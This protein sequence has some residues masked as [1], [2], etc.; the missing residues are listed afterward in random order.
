MVT[1]VPIPLAPYPDSPYTNGFQYINYDDSKDE[2]KTARTTIHN[3][4]MNWPAMM[5]KA[6][7]SM[8]NTDDTTFSRWF[9]EDVDVPG[10]D[11]PIDARGYVS[12]VFRQL[13]Q[14]STTSPTAKEVIKN[15]VNDKNDYSKSPTAPRPKPTSRPPPTP[16]TSAVSAWR[17]PP[18]P[19]TSTA[20]S[21]ATGQAGTCAR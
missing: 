5:Q 9:P 2:D 6:L 10:K 17:S 4:F 16:S 12:G 3:A 21:S 20:P 14:A 8:S 7:E 11:N 19:L 15:F 18:R 1:V 13:L